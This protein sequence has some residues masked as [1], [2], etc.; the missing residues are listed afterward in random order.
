MKTWNRRALT[1][2]SLLY[3]ATVGFLFT[4]VPLPVFNL[5][6][7]ALA[8]PLVWLIWA[9]ARA[10]AHQHANRWARDIQ[11]VQGVQS[12]PRERVRR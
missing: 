3:M 2:A 7:A 5:L 9:F 6:L 10:S 12:L 8:V 1:A 11:K 4:R